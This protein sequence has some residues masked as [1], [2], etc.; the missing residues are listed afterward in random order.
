M[1]AEIRS[2]KSE[3]V[4]EELGE[5]LESSTIF[6]NLASLFTIIISVISSMVAVRRYAERN[7]LQTSLMK[8]FG[9]SKKFIL[10]S[11]I[12]Q[13]TLMVVLA[14]LVGLG[15]GYLLQSLL[16]GALQGIITADLPPPS[17]TP[18]ILGFVTSFCVVF[19]VASPYLKILSESQPI[20]ILRND[21]NI[22]VTSN[23]MIYLVAAITMFVFLII[24]FKNI[25]LIFYIVGALIGVTLALFIIGK[26][27]IYFLSFLKLSSGIGWKLGLKNIVHRGNESILQI[28]IFGLSL[29]FLLVLAET[30]TDL[31]DSWTDTLQEDTPN[32]FLFNIQ[33]YDL[34]NISEYLN[35]E[36][37]ILPIFTPL[38]RGRLLSVKRMGSESLDSENIME[39]E[40]N[41]TWKENLPE[42]NKIVKGVW[43]DRGHCEC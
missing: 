31:V 10:G 18:V 12:M 39:R 29:V 17:F 38:I 8:V 28:I 27:L 2:Q 5:A 34:A 21:F 32:N 36:A 4:G 14:T 13:L 15:L 23:A 35:A 43:W 20:R 25:E 6:F 26:A 37:E 30:R 22:G 3:D 9:A 1:P 7:L 16:I 40:A 19:G 24:V 42:S 33:E 41:L 11:Q